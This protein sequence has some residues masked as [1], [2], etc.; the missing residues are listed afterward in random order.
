MDLEYKSELQRVL[1]QKSFTLPQVFIRGEY[2]GGA[3]LIKHMVE[4]GELGKML[5]GLPMK[6]PGYVCEFCGDARFV[7]CTNCSG[8]KKIF[9]E[10]EDQLQ[11]CPECN[12]NGLIRCPTCCCS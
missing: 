5:K 9:D 12:E 2:I 11:R 8:S 4:V 1:G 10:E 3:D 6:P 7:P